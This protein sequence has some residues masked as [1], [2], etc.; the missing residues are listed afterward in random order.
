MILARRLAWTAAACLACALWGCASNA[1]PMPKGYFG[2]TLPMADVIAQIDRNNDQLPTLWAR[3]QFEATIVDPDTHKSQYVNGYGNLLYRAPG[4]LRLVAKKEVTDLFDT[5]TNGDDFWLRV[6]PQQDTFW[7]G[8]IADLNSQPSTQIPLRPDMILEVLGIRPMES[9]LTQSPVPVMRFNN[10]AD[11]YMIVWQSRQGDHWIADKEIWYDRAT[12]HPIL[13]LLFDSDGRVVLRAWLSNFQAV[14][15]PDESSEDWPTVPTRYRLFF[16]QTGTK[17]SF[18]LSDVELSHNGFPKAIS[19][20]MPDP[21]Q[22]AASGVKV[23]PVDENK[24]S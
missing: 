13:V 18:D 8:K 23:I 9:D 19:F 2:A 14:H 20:R 11:A 22:L 7:W 15:I 17:M 3:H 24:G 10:D 16:P 5:G 6:V 4:S 21:G 12:L 1:P